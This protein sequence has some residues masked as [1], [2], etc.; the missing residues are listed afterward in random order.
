M[1]AALLL[2]IAPML[3]LL[4]LLVLLPF[5]FFNIVACRANFMVRSI[6]HLIR[7]QSAPSMQI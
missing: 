4:L 3:L 1:E 5:L 2:P 7:K 6:K